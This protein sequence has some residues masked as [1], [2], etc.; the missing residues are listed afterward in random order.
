[1]EKGKQ[2]AKLRRTLMEFS[3]RIM[4]SIVEE[5]KQHIQQPAEAV[6]QEGVALAQN[7]LHEE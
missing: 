2:V 7:I 6:E 4:L 3:N 1:M 5:A